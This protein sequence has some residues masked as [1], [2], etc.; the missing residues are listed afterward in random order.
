MALALVALTAMKSLFSPLWYRVA[1][2]KPRL[3]PHAELHRQRFRGDVWYVLQD[4]QTGRFHRISPVANLILSLMNGQRTVRE[5]WNIAGT[6]AGDDPPTQDEVIQLLAQLHGSDLVQAEIP[7]DIAEVA[8]RAAKTS[9]RE[10]LSRL[11]NPLALRFPVFDPDRILDRTLFLVRP[12]FTGTGFLVWLGFLLAA[13][14]IVTLNWQELTTNLSDRVL[15]TQNLF[16]ILCIYPVLKAFHEM[17]HAYATKVW[18]GEVHEIGVML[19]ILVPVP[20]VDASSASAFVSR[21]QRIIV[22][23]GGILVELFFASIAAIVWLNASPGLLR[24]VAFNVMLI[25]GVSTIAFNGNPLLRFDGYYILADLLEIPNLATRANRYLFYLVQRHLFRI[26]TEDDPVTGRG[27]QKWFLVYALASFVYRMFVALGIAFLLASKFLIFGAA[28]ALWTVVSLIVWPIVKGIRFIVTD[29]RLATNRSHAYA[30]TGGLAAVAFL[31]LF[32]VPMP[33]AVMAEGVVWIP[34]NAEVRSKTDGFVETVLAQPDS[35]VRA[36]LPLLQ[37]GN[38]LLDSRVRVQE[39]QL[40]EAQDRFDAA[41]TV[42]RVQAEIFQ[43]EINNIQSTLAHYRKTKDDLTV[44]ADQ[45]GQLIIPNLSD[46]PGRYVKK[47]DLLAYVIDNRNLIVRV[48]VTQDDIDLVR[49]RAGKVSIRLADRLGR[50]YPARIVREVPSGDQELPSLALSTKGG[51]DIALNPASSQ[52]PQAL[53]NIFQFDV[54]PTGP[55]HG[56]NPGVRVYVRFDLGAEPIAWRF[57]RESQQAFLSH[58]HL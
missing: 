11:R 36:S 35:Q 23:A 56:A 21:R 4:H 33:Y 12:L 38:P 37:L 42:D 15:A 16:I 52:K 39:A 24:T 30:V 17:G 55:V 5:L 25:G 18:G 10:M 31:L 22:G 54:A 9:R 2:L 29:S 13:I 20:Y 49:S 58:L 8:E 41:R 51:G 50:E 47:G 19:L 53:Y 48:V 3:R 26:D 27:E 14:M 1:D 34:Q 43:E 7:P 57:L 28:M 40:E 44:S 45:A 6:R 46:L 32:V